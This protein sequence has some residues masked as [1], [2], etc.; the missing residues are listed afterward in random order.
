MGGEFLLDTTTRSAT[1]PP[2]HP[3]GALAD[4]GGVGRSLPSAP[5]HSSARSPPSFL[6]DRASRVP[7][8]PAGSRGGW[9]GCAHQ[10]ERGWRGAFIHNGQRYIL[11][12]EQEQRQ[13]LK[14]G[15]LPTW[16]VPEFSNL[17]YTRER[18][19]ARGSSHKNRRANAASE[20]QDLWIHRR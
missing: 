17:A 16:F 11:V 15:T 13:F 3:P 8:A 2:H 4:L 1:D 5:T 7:A 14:S 12:S 18:E 9:L 20:M 6:P 19:G 10:G